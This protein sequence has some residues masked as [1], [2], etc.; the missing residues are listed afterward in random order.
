LPRDYTR[1]GNGLQLVTMFAA[2][3]EV[4]LHVTRI[5]GADQFARKRTRVTFLSYSASVAAVIS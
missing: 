2:I 1:R 3:A 4:T 5:A